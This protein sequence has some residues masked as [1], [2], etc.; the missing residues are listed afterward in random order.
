MTLVVAK[1]KAK[2]KPDLKR[3]LSRKKS[4]PQ[5][6]DTRKELSDE[7]KEK[8]L[9]VGE[10]WNETFKDKDRQKDTATIEL[11]WAEVKQRL[12]R[13]WGTVSQAFRYFDHSGDGNINFLEFNGMLKLMHVP[14]ETRVCRYV[15]AQ[16]A[17]GD[18]EIDLN[19]LKMILFIDT[20]RKLKRMTKLYRKKQD[21][22]RRH[23]QNFLMVLSCTNRQLRTQA[24][25][26]VQRKFTVPFCRHVFEQV[27]ALKVVNERMLQMPIEQ[28]KVDR[29]DVLQVARNLTGPIDQEV[30]DAS[31]IQPYQLS[32]LLHVFERLGNY[33]GYSVSFLELMTTI[34]MLSPVNRESD[35]MGKLKLL[36]DVHDTDYDGVL[37]P[38][39]ITNLF[40][41]IC[42]TRSEL[43]GSTVRAQYFGHRGQDSGPAFQDELSEQ[44]GQRHYECARW[45]LLRG[46]HAEGTITWSE[47]WNSIRDQPDVINSLVPGAPLMHW[48]FNQSPIHIFR[49]TNYRALMTQNEFRPISP[50]TPTRRVTTP[51]RS[52]L[53]ADPREFSP[54]GTPN[55]SRCNTPQTGSVF[56]KNDVWPPTIRAATPQTAENLGGR[57]STPLTTQKLSIR[58]STPLTSEK[59]GSSNQR[60]RRQ[61]SS[62]FGAGGRYNR[63]SSNLGRAAGNSGSAWPEVANE[64]RNRTLESVQFRKDLTERFKKRLKKLG[65]ERLAELSVSAY[66]SSPVASVRDEVEGSIISNSRASTANESGFGKS[67]M[68]SLPRLGSRGHS[69]GSRSQ[70]SMGL[71]RVSTSPVLGMG[72]LMECDDDTLDSASVIERL[73]IRDSLSEQETLKWG[74]E[75]LDR[76]RLLVEA[77]T[78]CR[79]CRHRQ[80]FPPT[81]LDNYGF[82]CALCETAHDLNPQEP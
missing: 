18:S 30:S 60:F 50:G 6:P 66:N 29:P 69:A 41:W 4:F 7:Q 82:R 57:A 42:K 68:L 16:A 61:T 25:D 38:D 62:G 26:R 5:Q 36:F 78:A 76:Y 17:Q 71:T 52:Q 37:H 8:D 10:M 11:F 27:K 49:T 32:W 14:L 13:R 58:G 19:E 2:A 47:L 22:F 23:V 44:E 46:G 48:A 35:R 73:P 9:K 77:H 34:V 21:R 81:A 64:A 51:V 54:A 15:F 40:S 65:N 33:T 39:Q 70:S 1:A 72:S 53:F 24:I 3:S 20:F 45:R 63:S 80:L 67:A 74:V 12:M 31:H 28:V 79:T 55:R 59:P 43:D 56:S 75:S